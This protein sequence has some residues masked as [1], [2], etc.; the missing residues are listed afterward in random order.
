MQ[1]CFK[2]FSLRNMTKYGETV[3]GRIVEELLERE[4]EG[5]R[6]TDYGRAL[7]DVLE[8]YA[9]I[10]ESMSILLKKMNDSH[11]IK[12][13]QDNCGKLISSFVRKYVPTS[14]HDEALEEMD[15]ILAHYDCAQGLLE[16]HSH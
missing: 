3:I 11:V 14:R 7:R 5:K 13:A 15:S 2:C 4:S 10:D 12:L 1:T 8:M 9:N 6:A 16:S